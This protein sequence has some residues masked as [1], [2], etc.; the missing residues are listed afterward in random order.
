MSAAVVLMPQVLPRVWATAATTLPMAERK[1][2]QGLRLVQSE[3]AVARANNAATVTETN[4]YEF[5]RKYTE[6]MLRRY[7]KMSMEAGRVP[8]LMGR[9]MFRGNVTHYKVKNFEDVVIF[10]HDVERCLDKLG[11]G[12]QHLIRRIALQQYTQGETAAMLGISLRSV[13]RNYAK[14]LDRLT[15]MFLDRKMLE[16]LEACRE[17]GP[18]V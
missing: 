14:A 13:V 9:E 7:M 8:S 1:G 2:P 10:T 3:A 16:P 5:Y 15:R 17:A 6:A 18:V 4:G 12:E 11:S